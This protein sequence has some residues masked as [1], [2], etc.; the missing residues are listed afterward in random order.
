MDRREFLKALPALLILPRLLGAQDGPEVVVVKGGNVGA[1]VRAGLKA[2]GGLGAFVR[3]GDRVLVKPNMAWDRSPELAANT[4]PEVVAALV[5]ACL[6]AGAKEVVVFDH[7]CEDPR[8]VYKG[9]GIADAARAAGARVPYPDPGRFKK[10]RIRGEVLKEWEVW[11]DALEVDIIINCPIL[12]HHS[13]ARLTMGMK[14]LMGLVGDPR[15]RL[16]WRLDEALSDLASFFRPQLV[17]L[18]AT[19]VLLKGGPQG[20]DPSFV[21]E[22][23]VIVMGRDQVAVDAVGAVLFGLKPQEVP[24]VVAGHRRGLGEM[25]LRRIGLKTLEV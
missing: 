5:R 11:Q 21:K 1:M 4:N 12:K 2:L 25:D 13:L 20:G 15:S 17:V 7:S 14:N 6:D 8:R 23:G 16:H 9:S 24:S 10:V 22:L 18:D 3:K 19:R